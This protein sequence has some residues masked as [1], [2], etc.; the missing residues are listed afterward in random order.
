[1]IACP[2]CK[3]SLIVKGVPQGQQAICVNCHALFRVGE[4]VRTSADRLAWR[5]LWLGL[6]SIVLLFI[7][8]IPAIY[9]GIRSLLRM[10]YVKSQTADRVA[11]ITGTALGG[12][13][14]L[15]GSVFGLT[16]GG[17]MGFVLL[18]M[19]RVEKTPEVAALF[20]QVFE[21]EIPQELIPSRGAEILNSMYFFDFYDAPQ[22][23]DRTFRLHLIAQKSII[24]TNNSQTI[25][26]LRDRVLNDRYQLKETG[27]EILT[28]SLGGDP[29]D[30]RKIEFEIIE[31]GFFN[32][33]DPASTSSVG[34]TIVQYY[35]YSSSE[36]GKTGFSWIVKQPPHPTVPEARIKEWLA[37]LK[38]RF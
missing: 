30:V 21:A 16:V 34:Q 23:I 37:K 38:P 4:Q 5:S 28:W 24:R 31:D 14:G 13:F 9:Y 29:I 35:G 36:Q 8:G 20:Q 33:D 18:T 19:V 1:M 7:T 25:N 32:P 12:C 11:A 3:T 6:S 22:P 15:F 27:S 17:L 10:R 26:Q 2:D